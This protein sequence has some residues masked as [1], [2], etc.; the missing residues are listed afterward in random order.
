MRV[1]DSS[2]IGKT[3]KKHSK[4][5]SSTGDGAFEGLLTDASDETSAG[6][7]TNQTV[8]TNALGSLLS[9]QTI[10]PDN[11]KQRQ[12]TID[13]AHNLLDTLESLRLELI[14]GKLDPASAKERMQTIRRTSPTPDPTMMPLIKDI[15]LRI[16]VEIAKLSNIL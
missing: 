10:E 4:K 7:A 15:E 13:Y 11:A 8:A 2:S 9:L 6:N 3:Q 16:E 1:S 12:D 14:E 5:T